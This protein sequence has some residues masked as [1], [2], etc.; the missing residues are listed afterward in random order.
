[1][2][3]FFKLE[4]LYGDLRKDANFKRLISDV[5]TMVELHPYPWEIRLDRE[6]IFREAR[7]RDLINIFFAVY[8]QY[9]AGTGKK[10]WGCKS[11][12][13][14]RHVAL[15]RRYYPDAKFLYLVRDGRDVAASAK[16]SIFNRYCVYYTARLWKEEQRTG[17]YWLNKLSP[18]GILLVKYDELLKD[19][20]GTIGPLCAFLK[21]P[22]EEKML[23]FFDTQEA[24]KSAGISAA[25]ANTS[26][27]IM[28]GNVNKFKTELT[29]K[30]IDLF[31]AI[32]GPELDY[33]SYPLEKEFFISEASR[34]R[35][36]KFRVGYL[37]EEIILML[38][39]QLRHLATDKNNILRFKKYWFLMF[40]RIIRRRR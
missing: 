26:K 10:R 6:R 11:T 1:M 36:V 24:K 28:S 14:I 17:I 16:K 32:A 20:G 33:F 12:F 39:A 29:G 27:P 9:L 37:F 18:E 38:R 7:G 25:W 4:P 34:A 5:V 13:M 15:I 40:I 3:N 2:N 8:N 31:E 35:G 19:P 21:E 23:N 22:F 30:E